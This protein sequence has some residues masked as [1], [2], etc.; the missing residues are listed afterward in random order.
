[1]SIVEVKQQNAPNGA[2][3]SSERWL[4]AAAPEI[5]PTLLQKGQLEDVAE[6]GQ[7]VTCDVK[8]GRGRGKRRTCAGQAPLGKPVKA[9]ELQQASAEEHIVSKPGEDEPVSVAQSVP[10]ASE[11]DWQHRE[12]KRRRAVLIVKATPDYQTYA[13]AGTSTEKEVGA[14]R[15]PDASDRAMSKRRW[16]QEVQQWRAS[17]RQWCEKH[18]AA[19]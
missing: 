10:P 11:D 12:E 9:S 13:E 16:E 15:T 8:R 1:M 4:N 18:R 3:S 7:P 5:V 14:P 2:A 19:E 6:E 17:L